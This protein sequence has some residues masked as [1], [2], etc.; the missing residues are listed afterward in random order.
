MNIYIYISARKATFGSVWAYKKILKKL[1]N[2]P[3]N[4]PTD[5]ER[6]RGVTGKLCFQNLEAGV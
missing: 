1:P 2:G 6:I 5:D 3:T 4:Q